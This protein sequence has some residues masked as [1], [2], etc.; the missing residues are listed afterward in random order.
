[1]HDLV[2]H[3][4]G[5]GRLVI[6]LHAEVP[7]SGDIMETHDAIDLIERRLVKELNCHAVIHMD[8]I[9]TDDQLVAAAREK[10]L[11][12][13]R[14]EFGDQLSIH[15]FRMVTGPTHTNVIF[16]AVLPPDAKMSV[17]DAKARISG[18]VE[19]LDGNYFAVVTIDLAYVM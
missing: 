4:Y 14:A 5:A 3:D 9:A 13:L 8:P 15:D 11:C 6:S 19:K 12:A 18:I 16:D 17:E 10:V 7:A 2:V 1:M